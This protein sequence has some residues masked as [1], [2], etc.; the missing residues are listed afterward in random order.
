MANII[1]KQDLL[2]A[3]LD[4][5]N[6]GH[7]VNDHVDTPNP[8][9][10]DGTFLTRTG[11]LLYNLAKLQEI[12]S[13]H[14]ET[15]RGT[16]DA[17]V[18]NFTALANSSVGD[19]Y[20][21]NVAGT[22]EGQVFEV[23]DKV[24]LKHTVVG[25]PILDDLD[26]LKPA[27][28]ITVGDFA[29]GVITANIAVTLEEA[30]DL[31]I[32]T[33]KAVLAAIL[34]N[35]GKDSI[36]QIYL[37]LTQS[38][39]SIVDNIAYLSLKTFFDQ[40]VSTTTYNAAIGAINTAI[41]N[42]GQVVD[43]KVDKI[44][45][46]GLSEF[47]F[48]V[49]SKEKLEGIEF[50]ANK[51]VD[52]TAAQKGQTRFATD[53]EAAAGAL[54]NVAINPKQ[55][56]GLGGGGSAGGG[57][58]PSNAFPVINSNPPTPG[59]LFT[60]SRGDHSHPID[61][62]RAPANYIE[63]ISDPDI[64]IN[65][66]SMG[67]DEELKIAVGDGL[68]KWK[69]LPSL[70]G[71]PYEDAPNMDGIGSAGSSKRFS[72]GDHVHPTDTTKVDVVDFDETVISL[73]QAIAN[74][75]IKETGKGLSSNDY[76][77]AEKEKLAGLEPSPY[78]GRYNSLVDL[79][80]AYPVGE[81]GWYADVVING[82]LHE[83][84]WS[85]ENSTWTDNGQTGGE[86]A[87]SI[88][89]K[90]EQNPD[91]NAYTDAEKIKLN[92]LM[93]IRSMQ[94]ES[95]TPITPD[96]DGK[97]T[98]PAG[99]G[100]SGSNPLFS[101]ITMPGEAIG[102]DALGLTPM[103]GQIT[104]GFN[105]QAYQAILDKWN[106]GSDGVMAVPIGNIGGTETYINITCRRVGS[107]NIVDVANLA[108]VNQIY[109]ATGNAWFFVLDRA[110][111]IVTLPRCN[112]FMSFT[113]DP[114]KVG[115]YDYDKIVDIMSGAAA[116]STSAAMLTSVRGANA[117]E[118][119]VEGLSYILG[120]STA[121]L[122]SR[123]LEVFRASR[124]VNT[125]D[126]VQPRNVKVWAYFVTGNRAVNTADID[127]GEVYAAINAKANADL[128][129]TILAGINDGIIEQDTSDDN[130]SWVKFKNGILV[131]WGAAGEESAT[132]TTTIS[133][134]L[135]VAFLNGRYVAV[136]NYLTDSSGTGFQWRYMTWHNKTSTSMQT[137]G[138]QN[139]RHEYI[140][141]GRWK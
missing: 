71:L 43:T 78:K 15:Y 36:K 53:A 112:D 16:F 137:Y 93:N 64:V 97:V 44:E 135:P 101:I 28:N 81:E 59:V 127:F 107:Y 18:G 7:F 67:L 50:Q 120:S 80:T 40:K 125:G 88:K 26:I 128:L 20:I 140:A 111:E 90:Y 4:A 24:I 73:Q 10:P 136:K 9:Y 52:A 61:I 98:L 32:P 35:S 42:L 68:T 84:I 141:I 62:S 29:A 6:I 21:V 85:V 19:Y 58:N 87:A 1:S 22:V 76:T 14:G 66:Q 70:G 96:V 8:G 132:T 100:G 79:Q 122:T 82:L 103:G 138:S 133:K 99:G 63:L 110:N 65:P 48:D 115:L 131:Q 33:E 119:N 57:A 12:Y 38:T 91:T 51:T 47:D 106:S 3:F 2:N 108:T 75:V 104:A 45:G 124:V 95:G 11:L 139:Q 30:S 13:A 56:M 5:E 41:S 123:V 94:T 89:Q 55:L 46:K 129:N 17:S 114:A 74:R 69:D 113:T 105:P 27:K 121:S 77:N 83:F 92:A 109:T 116:S 49:E 34:A 37:D 25:T 72:R 31:K 86:T 54:E 134:T 126:R 117:Y 118:Q 102:A 130:N 23:N 60:Y 39:I